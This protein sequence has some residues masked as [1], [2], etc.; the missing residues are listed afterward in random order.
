MNFFHSLRPLL[1]SAP[2]PWIVALVGAGGKTSALFALAAEARASGLKVLATTTTKIRDP[3]SE[4]R[5][6]DRLLFDS[7]LGPDFEA[8]PIMSGLASIMSDI[9]PAR[10]T[11]EGELLLLGS[12]IDG[13]GKLV[14]LHPSIF[15]R[16]DS[17]WDLVLV[18]ADGSRCLPI[19]APA[20]HEPVIPAALSLLIGVVGLD[21][22]DRRIVEGS[23][24]RPERLAALLGLELG[25]P[26]GVETILGLAA[27][28]EGL[29]KGAVPGLPRVLFLN[30][31]DLVPPEIAESLADAARRAGVAE[32]VLTGSVGTEEE[33]PQRRPSP[34]RGPITFPGAPARG[35]RPSVAG[36]VVVRGGGDLATGVVVRLS[37]SGFP[38][39]VLES[40]RP[41]A[42]RRTVAF[43]EAVYDGEALVEGL[44]ATLA[45]GVD[46]ALALAGSG[47]VP[48]LVDPSARILD[49]VRPFG[50]VDAIIAKRNLG[51]KRGGA[52][53]V[54]GLGPGF[55]AGK[56]VDAVVETNRGHNLGKVILS[57]GA[58]PDTGVPG[59]IAGKGA[60]RVVRAPC[61]GLVVG[62]REI[63]DL[64]RV[65]EPLLAIET[66]AGRRE[67]GSPLDGV[68]RGLI[69]PGYS[70]SPGFKIADVDPRGRPEHCHG[71]SDKARAIGGGV[72]EALLAL[73]RPGRD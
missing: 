63:G 72:L 59:I 64:V 16:L 6:F 50:L 1:A 20:E 7:R 31:A 14:G 51:T 18:E 29:F 71:V 38:V 32:L 28:P 17:R 2:R 46:E 5:R 45:S 55:E 54:I 40:E 52:E 13:E 41:S 34:E 24:H 39:V 48:V 68:L 67:V 44:R 62:I 66:A 42:I 26:V 43:S 19:K 25:A 37:R 57:G 27:A 61:E 60:E 30:K 65:G 58:E 70:V 53:V 33:R 49:R 56:D 9:V 47:I 10:P 35:D 3:R 23:V 21:A 73:A 11:G 4:G 22:L 12:G 8:A 15:S 69:R 36:L